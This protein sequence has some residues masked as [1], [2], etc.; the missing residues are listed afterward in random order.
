M[1]PVGFEPAVSAAYLRLRP[2][3][4]SIPCLVLAVIYTTQHMH[5]LYI[6]ISYTYKH[7]PSYMIQR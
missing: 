7:E 2:T 5:T 3:E 6:I 1:P 4:T